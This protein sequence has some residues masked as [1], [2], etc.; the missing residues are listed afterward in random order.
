MGMNISDFLKLQ[1]FKVLH[2]KATLTLPKNR[3]FHFSDEKIKGVIDEP[4]GMEGA[5]DFKPTGFWYSL[6]GDWLDFLDRESGFYRWALHRYDEW[7]YVYSI[8]LRFDKIL[9]LKTEK[10]FASFTK[11]YGVVLPSSGSKYNH[12]INWKRVFKDYDGIETIHSRE[13]ERDFLWFENWDCSSGCVW[14]ARSVRNFKL[15]KRL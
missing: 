6:G 15:I 2:R 3:R 10:E 14:R 12:L 11:K 5:A 9:R 13:R 8:T 7:R 4:E 1:N